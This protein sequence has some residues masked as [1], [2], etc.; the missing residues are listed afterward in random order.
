MEFHLSSLIIETVLLGDRL[1]VGRR[2]LNPLAG[3]RILLPQPFDSP[4]SR[5]A[6]SW[7]SAKCTRVECPERAK[8][9]EGPPLKIFPMSRIAFGQIRASR[10]PSNPNSMSDP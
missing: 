6:P 2:A 3:V 9:V 5:Q 7:P 8:R 10:A 1:V 4:A